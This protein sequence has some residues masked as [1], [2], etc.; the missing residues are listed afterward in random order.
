MDLKVQPPGS[1]RG[2]ATHRSLVN[3]SH[4]GSLHRAVMG[5]AERPGYLSFLGPEITRRVDLTVKKDTRVIGLSE[6]YPQDRLGT[7]SPVRVAAEAFRLEIFQA[8]W[9]S[10]VLFEDEN[11][12]AE[13]YSW[14]LDAPTI[15]EFNAS[16]RLLLERLKN[17]LFGG[18]TKLIL[19]LVN[20]AKAVSLEEEQSALMSMVAHPNSEDLSGVMASFLALAN[21]P[22]TN[23]L[24]SIPVQLHTLC[25]EREIDDAEA[26]T[27][28]AKAFVMG[29]VI[30]QTKSVGK[31][32]EKWFSVLGFD[33]L[34]DDQLEILLGRLGYEGEWISLQ[35]AL[36]DF[37]RKE[38]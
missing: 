32:R 9:T 26:R 3:R 20:I 16:T 22:A 2:S 10:H 33:W 28:E 14:Q 34:I 35:L 30:R 15:S 37:N 12:C 6:V 29:E 1:G 31:F 7:F 13:A 21:H 24:T 19:N 38:A 36:E 23:G 8:P 17:P 5:G 11:P 27:A 25:P 4:F 18:L